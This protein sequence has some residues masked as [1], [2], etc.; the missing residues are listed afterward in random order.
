MGLKSLQIQC[1]SIA[2]LVHFYGHS[3]TDLYPT[4][5]E[6]FNQNINSQAMNAANLAR[7]SVDAS[8]HFVANALVFAVQAVELRSHLVADTYDASGVLSESTNALYIAARTAAHRAPQ[9]DKPLVCNDNDDGFI[10]PRVEGV[11]TAIRNGTLIQSIKKTRD[12][13]GAL[14]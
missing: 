5:A 12:A 8:E 9:A 1:N 3:V 14:S 4:H 6:Q 10:Q 2:P 11:L 13:I 7:E